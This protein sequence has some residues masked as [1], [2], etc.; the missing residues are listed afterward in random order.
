MGPLFLASSFILLGGILFILRDKINNLLSPNWNKKDLSLGA[1]IKHA[2]SKEGRYHNFYGISSTERGFYTRD[3]LDLPGFGTIGNSGSGKT[4]TLKNYLL[5][6]L[7]ARPDIQVQFLIDASPKAMT[8]LSGVFHYENIIPALHNVKKILPAMIFIAEEMKRRGLVFTK[9][10]GTGDF[11]EFNE[12]YPAFIAKYESLAKEYGKRKFTSEE[13]EWVFEIGKYDLLNFQ[14]H[15]IN[16]AIMKWG[17]GEELNQEEIKLIQTKKVFHEL[18]LVTVAFDEFHALILSSE[19][20]YESNKNI[21]GSAANTLF[22]FARIARSLGMEAA[23][24]TQKANYREMPTDIKVALNILTSHRITDA[25]VA[26][27]FDLEVATN[28]NEN[29]KGRSIRKID[30]GKIDQIQSPWIVPANK[31][32]EVG[33]KLK[34]KDYSKNDSFTDIVERNHRPFVGEVFGFNLADAKKILADDGLEGFAKTHDLSG[35]FSN[36]T[37]LDTQEKVILLERLLK[38]FDMEIEF[39]KD[40][41][42]E[43]DAIITKTTT[44]KKYA[45]LI[46]HGRSRGG[47]ASMVSETKLS[48]FMNE[49]DLLGCDSYISINFGPGKIGAH[50]IKG[51]GGIVA[52]FEDLLKCARVIDS[53][54]FKSEEEYLKLFNRLVFADGASDEDDTPISR[55]DV[56]EMSDEELMNSFLYNE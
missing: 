45:T 19:L 36:H 21:P 35:V 3:V 18:A 32:E 55:K 6:Q 34:V 24:A 1:L 27:Q 8:D 12:K 43:A 26:S 47:M 49:N 46:G 54:S 56:S 44:G 37:F 22:I 25:S 17:K 28:I 42:L 9:T 29:L 14:N 7:I 51:A 2:R 20:D 23:V 52:E 16:E 31:K 13:L 11:K 15:S 40:E 41:S 39:V 50:K 48:N 10:V 38:Y 33:R 53:K 5:F 30:G 4:G